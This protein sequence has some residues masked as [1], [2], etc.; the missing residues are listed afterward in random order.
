MKFLGFYP[1][2]V[3][4]RVRANAAPPRL[5]T[6]GQSLGF[7]AGGFCLII[8]IVMAIA[9]VTDNLLRKHLGDKGGY[10]LDALLFILMA[11]GVFRRLV[12]AP[13]PVFRVY[14]LFASA[15]FLYVAAWTAAY[16]PFRNV[17]G[18]WLGSLAG[19]TG[20]GLVFAT[21]FDAPKQAVKVILVLCLTS[22]ACYFGVKLLY[23]YIPGIVGAL[24][25][26]A[27]YG[28]GMGTGLGY[29]LYACQEPARQRLKTLSASGAKASASRRDS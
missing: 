17:L 16:R 8:V 3:A 9:A 28:L 22:A 20:L 4:A 24:V 14:V 26:G 11:G 25:C 12:I 18:E 2:T 21:V 23:P 1:E 27:G 13:A 19:G 7:G 29:A 10:A 15:L 5:L 6:L